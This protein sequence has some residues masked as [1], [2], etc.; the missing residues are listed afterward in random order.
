MRLIFVADEVPSELQRIVE[1][2]N[3]Q[4]T[5]TEVLAIEVRRYVGE[6]FSTHVPRLLG[7]TADALMAK[8]PSRAGARRKWDEQ[9]FFATAATQAPAVQEALR[10]L[11]AL[12]QQP[13]FEFRWGT[14]STLGSLNFIVPAVS[15]RSIVTIQTNGVLKLNFGW[16]PAG[17]QKSLATFAR[18][19]MDLTLPDGWEQTWPEIRPEVWARSAEALLGFLKSLNS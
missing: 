9:S 11:Y 14:G 12:A 15:A 4:M 3:S 1:F 8:G 7:Q 2:L 6:G 19:T 5:K 13:G 17:A 16:L 18:S 10:N